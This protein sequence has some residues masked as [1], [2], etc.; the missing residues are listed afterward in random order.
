VLVRDPH[1][2]AIHSKPRH[3][4]SCS[5]CVTANV[6]QVPVTALSSGLQTAVETSRRTCFSHLD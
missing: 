1:A 4:A 3:P 5:D 6:A 2:V